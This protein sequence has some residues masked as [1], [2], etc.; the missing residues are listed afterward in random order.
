MVPQR[1]DRDTCVFACEGVAEVL[2]V[3]FGCGVDVSRV[4]VR[5]LGN[6]D[7]YERATALRAGRLELS[8]VECVRIAGRR[9]HDAVLVAASEAFSVHDHAA[10]EHEPTGPPDVVQ[11]REAGSRC[12]GRSRRRSR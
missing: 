3:Q 9:A 5:V 2:L 10:R 11:R 4:E 7:G 6:R 1:G 8:A 12:R